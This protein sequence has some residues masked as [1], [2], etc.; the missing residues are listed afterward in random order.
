MKRWAHFSETCDWHQATC[1][2]DG[3]PLYQ[4]W[5]ACDSLMHLWFQ[6]G[7]SIVS[8]VFGI[9]F[10]CWHPQ[11]QPKSFRGAQA[12]AWLLRI[13]LR[14]VY[15]SL[16]KDFSHHITGWCICCSPLGHQGLKDR[17]SPAPGP[18]QFLVPG[19]WSLNI[20]K[21]RGSGRRKGEVPR[22]VLNT[23]H[24]PSTQ[25]LPNKYTLS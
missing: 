19:G 6:K 5:Y 14:T 3:R 4:L 16:L 21:E 8:G 10:Y 22:W 18:T 12:G 9:W 24:S 15:T 23:Q 13:S 7:H 11:K 20:W 2:M 1:A 25:C 17:K